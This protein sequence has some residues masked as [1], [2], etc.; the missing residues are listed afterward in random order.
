VPAKGAEASPVLIYE[1]K[2]KKRKG[3][4]LFRRLDK[5]VRRGMTAE[6]IF[7]DDYLRRHAKSERQAQGRL[8]A[9]R[10]PTQ[11]HARGPQGDE[12]DRKLLF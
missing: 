2:K 9:R 5:M 4:P 3:S 10:L 6:R 7:A 1:R 8:G 11:Q 12:G